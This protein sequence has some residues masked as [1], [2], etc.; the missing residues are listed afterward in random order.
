MSAGRNDFLPP[1]R[2]GVATEPHDALVQ[3]LVAA[4]LV[5]AILPMPFIGLWMPP[6]WIVATAIAV[7]VWLR[8]PDP[9]PPMQSS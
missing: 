1:R 6:F 2:A 5:L 3:R 9:S 8:A 7:R 4:M